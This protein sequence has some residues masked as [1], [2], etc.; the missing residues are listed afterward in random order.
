MREPVRVVAATP[1]EEGE[2][3]EA[4][5]PADDSQKCLFYC[6]HSGGVRGDGACGECHDRKVNVPGPHLW[7]EFPQHSSHANSCT[8]RSFL[9]PNSRHAVMGL[10]AIVLTKLDPDSIF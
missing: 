5:I 2:V 10:P 8:A 7:V 4:L 6:W 9:T 3:I 1:R